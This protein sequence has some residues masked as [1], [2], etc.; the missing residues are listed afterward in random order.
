MYAIY[1]RF[2]DPRRI[3]HLKG[4][5][6]RFCFFARPSEHSDLWE[7]AGEELHHLSK[8]LR[9]TP[10]TEVDLLREDGSASAL[11]RIQSLDKKICLVEILQVFQPEKAIRDTTLLLGALDHREI[12][13]IVPSLVELGLNRLVVF[14]DEGL[15]KDR[16]SE[17]KLTRW[18]EIAKDAQKQ[19]KR[20][21]K[22]EIL[23]YSEL[24]NYL[25]SRT[26]LKSE[27]LKRVVFSSEVELSHTS[28]EGPQDRTL[29]AGCDLN[30]ITSV[31]LCTSKVPIIG[32]VGPEKGLSE[33]IYLKLRN[34][35]NFLPYSLG[36]YTLKATTAA[37]AAAVFM[38]LSS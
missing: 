8:V 35:F 25:Y 16:I 2:T 37:L 7:I 38:S 17:V 31:S 9:I 10:G 24:E 36:P 22:L 33:N 34:D 32:C 23:I 11:G 1:H 6:H 15:Q 3:S 13:K 14:L 21:S 20:L 27:H 29:I 28:R 30:K 4:T 12:D 26:D 5:T 19:C 18:Q